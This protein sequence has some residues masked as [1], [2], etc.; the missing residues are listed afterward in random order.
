MISFDDGP[1]AGVVLQLRRAPPFLRVVIDRQTR[2][3]DAL[4]Q[5]DDQPR[6]GEEVHVYRRIGKASPY[7]L[8]SGRKSESGFYLQARYQHHEE[9]PAD[10]VGRDRRSWQNWAGEQWEKENAI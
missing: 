1:A 4:D 5:I 9:Q 6:L 8:R 7:H 3:V 2:E 10:H